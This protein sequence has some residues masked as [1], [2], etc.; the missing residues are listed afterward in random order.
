M[1]TT[2]DRTGS[3]WIALTIGAVALG[4][5]LVHNLADLPGQTP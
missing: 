1:P 3:A 5:I 4:R 2:G